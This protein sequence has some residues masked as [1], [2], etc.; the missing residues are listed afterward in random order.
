[1]LALNRTVFRVTTDWLPDVEA[2]QLR[3]EFETEME[4]LEAARAGQYRP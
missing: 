1:M 4:R 2:R 3:L